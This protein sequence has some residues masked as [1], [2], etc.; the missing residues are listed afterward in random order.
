MS[1][2]DYIMLSLLVFVCVGVLMTSCVEW[3][4]W[5]GRDK[6]RFYL[7]LKRFRERVGARNG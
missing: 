1:A 2:C 6:K 4:G 3:D 7:M 5:G